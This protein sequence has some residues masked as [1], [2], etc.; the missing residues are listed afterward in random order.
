MK[1][2]DLIAG[3]AFWSVTL[4]V[5]A[6]IATTPAN[7]CP[8][9]EWHRDHSMGVLPAHR[10]NIAL[11]ASGELRWNSQIVSWSKLPAKLRETQ[12]AMFQTVIVFLPDSDTPCED[13]MRARIMMNRLAKCYSTFS[14]GE[15]PQWDDPGAS[16]RKTTRSTP[17]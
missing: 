13:K 12:T 9:F 6:W 7:Q 8:A 17:L 16:P 15:G 5:C 4:C 2:E 3:L 10:H 14:C 1:N 11:N